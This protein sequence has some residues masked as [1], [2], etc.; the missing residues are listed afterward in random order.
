MPDDMVIFWIRLQHSNIID[1]DIKYYANKCDNTT[2]RIKEDRQS[3]F[4]DLF[5]S[6]VAI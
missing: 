4:P 5:V 2:T 3:V 1:F 6:G